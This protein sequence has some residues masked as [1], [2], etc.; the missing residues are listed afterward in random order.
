M[1]ENSK[2]EWTDAT[3]TPVVG[4]DAV[5]PGCANCYAATM[6][7]RLEGMGQPK[8]AGLATR[9]GSK[10]KWTGKVTL[11]EADLLAP[12][13]KRK[14][15][16]WFLTSMGDVFH[17]AVPFEFM[18]RL[19]A[20]MA[21]CQQHT[22]QVLTKRP[23]RAAAYLN[24]AARA[25][26]ASIDR[27]AMSIG[28]RVGMDEIDLWDANPFGGCKPGLPVPNVLIGTTA[29]DQPRADERRPHMAVIAAAGWRTFVSYEPALSLVDWAGWEFLSWLISG[30][31]SGPGARPSHPDWHRAARDFCATHGI[32]YMMKQWGEWA[33]GRR[34]GVGDKPHAEWWGEDGWY[35]T[36]LPNGCNQEMTRVGKKAA[37]RLLDGVLHDALPAVRS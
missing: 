37:G 22:F 25:R 36:N 8:Y 13:K 18:D 6:A 11:S 9:V 24:N 23:E 19:F 7:A 1:G 28:R 29:E 27:A 30:G 17:D 20:V 4:C 33:P 10:G 21:L 14:P 5:S 12:L 32:P 31:E 3:W 2:I 26:E 34:N 16:K 15:T 35:F